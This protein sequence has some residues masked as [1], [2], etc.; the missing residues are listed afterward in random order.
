MNSNKKCVL[1]IDV[2][3][4]EIVSE[5]NQGE[6]FNLLG[7]DIY[8]KILNHEGEFFLEVLESYIHRVALNGKRVIEAAEGNSGDVIEI[9]DNKYIIVAKGLSGCLGNFTSESNQE[10]LKKIEEEYSS[11][12]SKKYLW[13]VLFVLILFILQLVLYLHPEKTKQMY[14]TEDLIMSPELQKEIDTGIFSHHKVIRV[15][16][17]T[18]LVLDDGVV[19]ALALEKQ[20]KI[21]ARDKKGVLISKKTRTKRKIKVI[22]ASLLRYKN[23]LTS[24]SSGNNKVLRELSLDLSKNREQVNLI[25]SKYG[26]LI[27]AWNK[28]IYAVLSD[29]TQEAEEFKQYLLYAY[30]GHRFL[31]N[32]NKKIYDTYLLKIESIIGKY[33]IT[34][35][36]YPNKTIDSLKSL[37]NLIPLGHPL[38]KEIDLNILSID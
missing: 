21:V 28:N 6:R 17:N 32:K 31:H 3:S 34:S 38:I 20:D 13:T 30:Q 25:K 2:K 11:S 7:D 12:G 4:R 15:D 27:K 10:E 33:M 23:K 1:I 22:S 16:N 37:K 24:L 8:I 26:Y 29:K 35:N 9:E 14:L 36:L 18:E 19:E 5:L